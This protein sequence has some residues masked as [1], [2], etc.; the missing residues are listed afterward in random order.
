[1]LK[2]RL[3]QYLETVKAGEEVIVT[4]RGRPIA[5]LGPVDPAAQRKAHLDRLIRAGLA[6]PPLKKL[7]PQALEA[8]LR[9]TGPADPEGR[10]LAALLEDRAQGR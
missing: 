5:R 7:T 10:V 6:R 8:L 9:E 3:S 2:A 4:E 1:M